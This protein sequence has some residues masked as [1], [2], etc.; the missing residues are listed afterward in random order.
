MEI[1][2][3]LICECNGKLYS[4]VTTLKDHRRSKIHKDWE[5]KKGSQND[6]QES[7]NNNDS[8]NEQIET[9][10]REIVELK[11]EIEELKK[12]VIKAK[13]LYIS[14]LYDFNDY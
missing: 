11:A 7:K 10:K 3:Q 12:E 2:P 1:S 9:Y 8:Q 14:V 5:S 4:S 13:N 6:S